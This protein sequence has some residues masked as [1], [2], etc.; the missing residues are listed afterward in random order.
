MGF[1]HLGGAEAGPWP[2]RAARAGDTPATH[3]RPWATVHTEAGNHKECV[4]K[5]H[6]G[7]RVTVFFFHHSIFFSQGWYFFSQ[8]GIFFRI[9]FH[10][11]LFFSI[12]GRSYFFHHS[13]FSS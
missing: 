9:F 8:G 4:W 3:E 2:R 6:P 7:P 11:C 12:F 10:K 1:P 5:S 13:I